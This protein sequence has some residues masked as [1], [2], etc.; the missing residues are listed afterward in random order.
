ME[1][2]RT[3][4]LVLSFCLKIFTV[5][6]ALVAVFAL[7]RRRHWPAAAPRTRFAAVIAARNEE[8]VIGNLVRSLREQDYPAQLCDIYVVPNNCTDATEAAARAAGANILR[9]LAPVTSKGGALHHAFAQLLPL[10]YDAF[11]VFDADNV[12]ERD[13]LARMNDAF[14]AGAMVCKGKTRAANPASSAV[15]GCYGLYNTCFDLIWNRPRAACGLSAK[16]VGTGFGF[17][18]EVLERLGGWNTDTIAEDAEFAAQC[19]KAGF[20][21][22]W[23]PEAVGYD[24]E[25]TG[26]RLSLRQRRRWCSGVM[27][28]AKRNVGKLWQS[29]VPRPMLRWDMTMFL[30][31]PFAQAVSGLLLCAGVLLGIPE[32]GGAAI[33]TA[34]WGLGLY[35]LGGMALG[36]LLCV[37]GGYALRDMAKSILFFPV[38]MASWLPLQ[39]IS[40]FHDTTQWRQIEHCGAAVPHRGKK[41][42]QNFAPTGAK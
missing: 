29:D 32:A 24:E 22:S 31:A 3:I 37:L 10:G 23:V 19:A 27:Q 6:F 17:R 41:A 30:A 26:F 25:P 34:L 36:L 21:V 2:I 35:C 9:C 5:Y 8:A 7:G 38:F 40:L 1:Q 11:L 15:A 4:L 20:R 14:A 13:Y 12:L 42:S 33:L 39:I 18:R 16:L 28:V